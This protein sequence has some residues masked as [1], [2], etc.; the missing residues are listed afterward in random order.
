MP[1]NV[2][3]TSPPPSKCETPTPKESE[4]PS[5]TPAK[6]LSSTFES[7]LAKTFPFCPSLM[8]HPL[9]FSQSAL[10]SAEIFARYQNQ[11]RLNS[12]DNLTDENGNH[13]QKCLNLETKK[14]LSS[15][16]PA[17]TKNSVASDLRKIDQIAENLRCA[18]N[19]SMETCT[20]K[21]N[22][23]LHSPTTTLNLK[24]PPFS[25]LAQHFIGDDIIHRSSSLSDSMLIDHHQQQQQKSSFSSNENVITDTLLDKSVA[26]NAAA[27]AAAVCGNLIP[28]ANLTKTANSKLYATCFI[29]HK[30]LSNQYNLRVHL[31]T[32]QNVRYACNVCSH[33]SRS[34]DALR[35]HVSYRHPGA[36]SPCDSDARRKRTKI[37]HHASPLMGIKNENATIIETA[38][39]SSQMT[40]QQHLTA[41]TQSSFSPIETHSPPLGSTTTTYGLLTTTKHEPN[42]PISRDHLDATQS[43]ISNNNSSN[44]N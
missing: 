7:L 38:A 34:K 19:R 3:K 35:K 31:E 24:T 37:V 28:A 17:N 10:R 2:Q 16:T 13:Q 21:T 9:N 4:T 20:N 29:C 6:Q 14:K 32:H 33:V 40:L 1:Q 42:S 5:P 36:S 15:T 12:I 22:V 25:S 41:A 23:T 27:A 18:T 11:C 39:T 8:T 44:I 30:Q 43:T 26:V